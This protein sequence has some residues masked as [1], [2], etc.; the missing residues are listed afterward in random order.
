MRRALL[1]ACLLVTCAGSPALGHEGPAHVIETLTARIEADGPTPALLLRRASEY[2]VLGK[3]DAAV[4]DLRHVIAL[5]PEHLGAHA[6]LSRSLSSMDQHDDALATVNHAISLT[7]DTGEHPHLHALRGDILASAKQYD[8][9]LAEYDIA[10]AQRPKEIDWYLSRAAVQRLMLAEADRLAG[11]D[12]GYRATGSGVLYAHWIDALLDTDEK[13]HARAAL[14]QIDARLE[15]MRLKST[16]LIRRARASL[17]LGDN[18]AAQHDLREAI[19]EIDSRLHPTR[20]DAALLLDR[21]FAH[22][23]LGESAQ[24]RADL[25]LAGEH[26]ADARRLH[27]L[28]QRITPPAESP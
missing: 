2:R 22:H 18:D 3:L 15:K 7:K 4:A 6:E 21:A 25:T 26:H 8:D 17:I 13:E 9:A 1:I 19:R 14:T 5:A 24:A 16:W 28:Q 12:A 23:L 11:L 20:P 27:E 10:I